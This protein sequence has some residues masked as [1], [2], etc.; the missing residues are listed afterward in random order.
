M[1][2]ITLEK[3]LC[4]LMIS[5]LFRNPLQEHDVQNLEQSKKSSL[6]AK[7]QRLDQK[8]FIS[9]LCAGNVWN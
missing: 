1:Y 3:L 4:E 8:I 2:L 5:I 7:I 6:T 9:T